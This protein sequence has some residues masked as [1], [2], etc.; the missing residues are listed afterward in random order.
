[1]LVSS[2]ITLKRNVISC[3]PL[4]EYV[5]AIKREILDVQ[6]TTEP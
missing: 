5:E 3:D 4:E 1:M 2:A 6:A